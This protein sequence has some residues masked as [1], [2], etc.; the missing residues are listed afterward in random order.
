MRVMGGFVVG[1]LFFFFNL[2]LVFL[3]NLTDLLTAWVAS[4]VS[5]IN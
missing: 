1:L 4:R 5:S 3:P 2:R